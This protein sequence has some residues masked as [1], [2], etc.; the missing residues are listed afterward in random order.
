MTR[1][2]GLPAQ[3][4]YRSW[5]RTGRTGR[6]TATPLTPISPD[7]LPAATTTAS[8]VSVPRSVS[9]MRSSPWAEIRRTRLC[10][11]SCAPRRRAEATSARV[12]SFALTNPCSS[13]K[14][15][16]TALPARFGSSFLTAAASSSDERTPH[17]ARNAALPCS[18]DH[19]DSSAATVIVP[20]RW[21]ATGAPPSETARSTKSL[22][23]LRLR[24]ARSN[25]GWPWRVSMYG[26]RMPAE[27]CVAPIPTGRSSTISTDAPRCANSSAT[28]QPTMPAPIT[29]MSE[30]RVIGFQL[31]LHYPR[32]LHTAFRKVST[33]DAEGSRDDHWH[34]VVAGHDARIRRPDQTHPRTG[35]LRTIRIVAGRFGR[36][37]V[38]R[39]PMGRLRAQSPEPEQRTAHHQ[40]R[41]PNGHSDRVRHAADVF[42]RLSLGCLQHRPV[43]IAGGKA[44]RR[45]EDHQA[46]S[47]HPRPGAGRENGR[48]RHRVVR[49]QRERNA[50]RDE[51][52]RAGAREEAR[53][54]V[55]CRAGVRRPDRIHARRSTSR[56][57]P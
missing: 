42:S 26:A 32:A 3:F 46:Q 16:P 52:L 39:R 37:A 15:A 6:R 22:Y 20:F 23:R 27:A 54:R 43:R 38:S 44:A 29:M 2:I 19:S 5:P 50:S 47:G 41:G 28:A 17:R 53:R 11:I 57:G 55:V 18:A 40:S 49:V 30:G 24:S 36:R 56:D 9:T 25:R 48:G 33:H 8:A 13:I 31:I 7:Q 1:R 21:Y 14:S 34:P 51:A 10:S 35:G 45:E 4:R 12:R